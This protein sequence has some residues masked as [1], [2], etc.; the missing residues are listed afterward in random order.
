M[1]SIN[2]GVPPR[3]PD[4]GEPSECLAGDS[5]DFID[6]TVARITDAEMDEHLREVLDQGG[7]APGGRRDDQ[8]RERGIDDMD[9]SA[10]FSRCARRGVTAS[11]VASANAESLGERLRQ[12]K[13]A[14]RAVRRRDPARLSTKAERAW[15]LP[16]HEAMSLKES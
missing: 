16:A 5:L 3:Q 7:H 2:G 8:Q 13:E 1:T 15:R 9:P 6:Q 14:I 4:E 11:Y 10:A 12:A